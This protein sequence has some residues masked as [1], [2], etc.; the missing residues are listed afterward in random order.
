MR[1]RTAAIAATALLLCPRPARSEPAR[2]AA[3]GPAGRA[4]GY[5]LQVAGQRVGWAR[6]T[7]GPV[8]RGAR[9]PLPISLE[10]RLRRRVGDVLPET[11]LTVE[12]RCDPQPPHEFPSGTSVLAHGP[13]VARLRSGP[14][15]TVVRRDATTG[16]VLLALGGFAGR[17][18]ARHVVAG[19]TDPL[20]KARRLVRFVREFVLDTRDTEPLTVPQIP[21]RREGDGSGHA[22]LFTT[23][24]RVAGLPAREVSGFAYRGDGTPVLGW[25]ARAEVALGDRWLPVDPM[26]GEVP[27]DATHVREGPRG[28]VADL[29]QAGARLDVLRVARRPPPREIPDAPGG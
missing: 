2:A 5:A 1:L 25:H 8:R 9:P 16:A 24:A 23:L 13:G 26:R 18:L 7:R 28:S 12:K 4:D 3:A 6:R 11:R 14:R 19:A 27:A 10:L 17:P 21:V 20:I 15:Q 22:L 29:P